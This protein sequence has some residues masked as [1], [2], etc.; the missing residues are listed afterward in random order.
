METK[1]WFDS[2]DFILPTKTARDGWR[3]R[4][5]GGKKMAEREKKSHV[6]GNSRYISGSRELPIAGAREAR[7]QPHLGVL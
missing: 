4:E 2:H 3:R 5:E 7:R 1:N 6:T